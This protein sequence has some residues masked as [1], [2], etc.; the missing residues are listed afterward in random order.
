MLK[1][2]TDGAFI[3]S[4]VV[5]QYALEAAEKIEKKYSKHVQVIDMPTIKPVDRNAI[6]EAAKTGNIIV[7]QDHNV[8]GGLGSSV[9]TILAEE[10]ISVKFKIL[11]LT[12]KFVEMAHAPYLYHKFEYDTEGLE[13]NLMK[14]IEK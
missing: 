2:G 10:G 14:I 11:G 5:V 13:K 12:D 9:A 1:E 7:A 4:G 8:I 6:I 3:C